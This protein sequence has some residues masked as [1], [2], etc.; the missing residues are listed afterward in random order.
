MVLAA[1]VSAFHTS[2][3]AGL[4]WQQL[5]SLHKPPHTAQVPPHTW[6]QSPGDVL[7]ALLVVG[8]LEVVVLL[9]YGGQQSFI[10]G[11]FLLYP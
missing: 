2:T 7:T 6:G 4:H 11:G 3:A 9:E 8:S 1:G 10:L 5:F